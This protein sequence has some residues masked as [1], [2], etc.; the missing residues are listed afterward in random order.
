MKQHTIP[1]NAIILERI[2][3]EIGGGEGGWFKVYVWSPLPRYEP[4]TYTFR[5]DCESMAAQRGIRMF[6]EE[7]GAPP[8][9]R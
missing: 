5:A 3:K 7:H 6:E 4:R 1:A 2:A 9:T 8:P